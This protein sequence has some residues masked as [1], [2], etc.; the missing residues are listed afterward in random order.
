MGK[1]TSYDDIDDQLLADFNI[2]DE[3]DLD[4]EEVDLNIT[5]DEEVE[6][7]EEVDKEPEE[8][9]EPEKTEETVE[10]K[11]E[12]KTFTK[13][14]QKEYNFKNLRLEN[15]KLKE[16]TQRLAQEAEFVK[17]LALQNGYTDVEAFKA[18]LKEAQ[19]LKEAQTKGID[20]AQYK[21][22]MELKE[23]VAKLEEQSKMQEVQE[24]A[25]NFKS[26]VLEAVN[27]YELGEGGQKEI[28]D[29]LENAGFTVE[30]IL[31]L[32]N[33][34]IVIDGVLA[35]IIKTNSVQAQLAKIEKQSK[36]AD[37]RHDDSGVD[38]KVTLD[39]LVKSEIEEYKKN[40]Y[41]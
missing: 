32:P 16:E 8:I 15:S 11:S 29:R 36:V 37:T 28:L 10:D 35:D 26:A 13:D 2:K 24:K 25:L 30:S 41:Y 18:D 23:K 39:D 38:T 22:T 3:D 19:M 14:E 9:E 21:E 1:P 20:P 12:P 7:I 31:A 33:P 5:E 27:E 6:E 17:Q 34:K 4:D 40:N